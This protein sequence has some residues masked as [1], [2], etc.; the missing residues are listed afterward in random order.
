[1]IVLTASYIARTYAIVVDAE[2][3]ELLGKRRAPTIATQGML[4]ILQ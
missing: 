1:M 4:V 2:L 3:R